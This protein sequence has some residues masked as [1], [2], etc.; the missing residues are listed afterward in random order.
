MAT[1]CLRRDG[2]ISALDINVTQFETAPS[3][4][5]CLEKTLKEQP[6]IAVY[7]PRHTSVPRLAACLD[8]LRVPIEP[9][10]LERNVLNNQ[11]KALTLYTR[12]L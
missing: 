9:L 4:P 2:E 5:Q 6:N 3:M 10:C 7:L 8:V 11:L 1:S 12:M